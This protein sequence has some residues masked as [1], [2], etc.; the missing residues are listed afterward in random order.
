MSGHFSFAIL[1]FTFIFHLPF[2]KRAQAAMR[3]ENC[4]LKN[5]HQECVNG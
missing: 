5:K 2:A 4:K 3:N 1:Q